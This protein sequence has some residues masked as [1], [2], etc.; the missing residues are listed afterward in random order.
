MT[1]LSNPTF[2]GVPAWKSALIALIAWSPHGLLACA[3]CFGS[4]DS[5]MARGMSLGILVLLVVVAMVLGGILSA[6]LV[7]VAR[8]RRLGEAETDDE[9]RESMEGKTPERLR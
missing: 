7:M 8:A 4:S 5:D 2:L 3:T 1:T 6:G 9:Q